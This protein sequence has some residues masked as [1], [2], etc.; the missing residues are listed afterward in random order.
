MLALKVLLEG[1]GIYVLQTVRVDIKAA[2]GALHFGHVLVFL[3]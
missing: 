1:S 2:V 3:I